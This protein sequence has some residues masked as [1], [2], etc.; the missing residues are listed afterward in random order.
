MTTTLKL[1]DMDIFLEDPTGLQMHFP[2]NPPEIN[3]KRDKSYE[4]LTLALQG[5]F[6]IPGGEKIKEIS[7]SSFFPIEHEPGYCRTAE[8]PNPQHA[9]NQLN[10]WMVSR[11]PLR[12]IITNTDVNVL[13]MI[14]SH[15]SS[16]RG[17]EPG[18]VYFD[19]TFRT[20][21]E[22]KVRSVSEIGGGT[23]AVEPRPDI[24]PVPKTYTVKPGDTLWGI[25]KLNLG[26][27]SRWREIY[28]AN[29]G[30]IGPDSDR[31]Y[32]GQELVMPG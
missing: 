19:L 5:E 9:M 14:A 1:P 15:N 24:K 26:S 13:V 29:A 3:I 20:W 4:T 22:Y 16:F 28:D 31:I 27:G 12:L 23:T 2:V 17:G 18:D 10:T 30:V 11:Q 6:D 25:A 7:F 21:R 8:V 32:P